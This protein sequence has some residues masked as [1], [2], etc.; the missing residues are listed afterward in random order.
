MEGYIH[1]QTHGED[2]MKVER[3]WESESKEELRIDDGVYTKRAFESA[4]EAVGYSV[5]NP[6]NIIEQ[7]TIGRVAQMTPP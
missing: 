5:S 1:S 6:Y 4:L 7:G 3:R 2:L